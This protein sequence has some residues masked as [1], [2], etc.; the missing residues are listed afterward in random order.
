MDVAFA[1][2]YFNLICWPGSLYYKIMASGPSGNGVMDKALA[3]RAGG[4][5]SIPEVP[6]IQMKNIC[7]GI[8][9]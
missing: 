1:L 3:C 8:R 9:W 5:G 6:F 2:E 4:P 7:F